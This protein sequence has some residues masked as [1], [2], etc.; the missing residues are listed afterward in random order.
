MIITFLLWN[1][2]IGGAE[3]TTVAL[4]GKLRESHVDTNV[5]FVRGPDLLS[6]QLAIAGVPHR[7][8][9]FR[10]GAEVAARPR[11]L[12]EAVAELRTDVAVSVSVGYLGAALRAGGFRGPIVGVEHGGLLRVR[13]QPVGRRAL[14]WIGRVSGVVT[15]DAEIAVSRYMAELALSGPH[16]PVHLV[17]HG[18]EVPAHPAPFPAGRGLTLGYVGRLIP[19]KGVD[20]LLHAIATVADRE[21]STAVALRV[22]GDGPM[23]REWQR[24]SQTLGIAQRV[25]FLGWTDDVAAH[26][27]QCDVAVAP[28]DSFAESFCMSML[29]AMAAGRPTLVTDRGG[30][31]ELVIE[32]TT[33]TVVPAGRVDRLA[34]AI[35]GYAHDPNRTRRHGNAA[36]RRALQTY[37]LDRCSQAYLD[38]A[39]GLL[40]QASR[41]RW[42]INR[43][44]LAARRPARRPLS[45]RGSR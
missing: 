8:L 30:L 25:E 15:H 22:A 16:A 13:E 24:L 5:L 7:A 39:G 23:R 6:P 17:P 14:E 11:V 45:H 28:N 38:L 31:P 35:A 21:P 34:A 37:S 36:W 4:A 29:E 26:W 3:R 19:G 12:A 44:R 1:G 27:Q 40:A 41:R 20:R 32:D 33:G 2:D 10:R 18:V 43:A 9:G 42:S